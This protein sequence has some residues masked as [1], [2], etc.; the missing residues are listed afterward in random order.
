MKDYFPTLALKLYRNFSKAT[1][2]QTILFNQP[3]IAT[4]ASVQAFFMDLPHQLT[5]IIDLRMVQFM[6]RNAAQEFVNQINKR[7]SDGQ[8]LEIDNASPEV[9]Q[10]LQF[11]IKPNTN[12]NRL[13]TGGALDEAGL[14]VELISD[15]KAVKR[16]LR[17]F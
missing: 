2:M 11:A 17:E 4:R 16:A 10:M 13:P 14:H 3:E 5:I 12:L 9:H 1:A 6:A 8:K 7:T 15:P